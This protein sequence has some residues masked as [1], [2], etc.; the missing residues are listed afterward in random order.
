V[1]LIMKLSQ[2]ITLCSLVFLGSLAVITPSQA[3][4]GQVP[5]SV[6]II[7][8]QKIM[9]ESSAGKAL[10][11]AADAQRKAIQNDLVNKEQQLRAAQQQLAQQRASMSPAD[12]Q[13][14]EDDLKQQYQA[15]RQDGEKRRN[16]FEASY[17]KAISQIID[18]LSKVVTEIS[19]QR[20]I[21]LVLNKSLVVISAQSWDITSESMQKLNATLPSVKM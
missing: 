18:T 13:K 3:Q 19:Q 2:A 17:N 21:T 6:G 16:D 8:F 4:Q 11:A 1:R 12:Y 15:W 20:G 7:D 9:R 10:A 14:K 5:V